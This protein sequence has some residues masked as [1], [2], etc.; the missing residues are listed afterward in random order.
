ML[1]TISCNTLLVP[2]PF[3]LPCLTPLR[4]HS[5]HF[6]DEK[7]CHPRSHCLSVPICKTNLADSERNKTDHVSLLLGL[8]R[9]ARSRKVCLILLPPPPLLRKSVCKFR[10]LTLQDLREHQ[11]NS[12]CKHKGA[13]CL[14][15]ESCYYIEPE[16]G[17]PTL[18]IKQVDGYRLHSTR[19]M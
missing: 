13:T 2:S 7:R 19:A 3:T 10:I 11:T 15:E 12:R 1:T 18:V 17:F 5:E 6:S 8:I 4:T 16:K 14:K 9:T